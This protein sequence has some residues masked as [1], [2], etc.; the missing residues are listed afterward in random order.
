MSPY[1]NVVSRKRKW[2][3][4]AVDKGVV[5]EGS[6]ETLLRSLALRKLELPVKDFLR[7]GLEKDLPDVPGVMEALISNQADEDKHDLGLEYVVKA[8]GVDDRAERESKSIVNA[9]L[10]SPEHPILKASILE[11][12]VFLVL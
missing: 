8:H 6:E 11:R 9:W 10:E 3:P 12:S 7:Q 2:T 1:L 4:L 5:T